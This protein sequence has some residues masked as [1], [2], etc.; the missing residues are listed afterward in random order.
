MSEDNLNIKYALKRPGLFAVRAILENAKGG[1]GNFS[2]LAGTTLGVQ[3]RRDF[4]AYLRLLEKLGWLER[5]KLT[6][7]DGRRGWRVWRFYELT[8]KGRAFL[9]LF[10]NEG[11]DG[12]P[13]SKRA[14]VQ[15]RN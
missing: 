4:S 13:S 9:D 7:P 11:A 10:P 12:N 15:I 8:A 3:N 2:S 1:W 6:L 14:S 5:D